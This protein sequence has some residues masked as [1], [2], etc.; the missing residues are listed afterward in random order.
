M[1]AYSALPPSWPYLQH[2]RW[3]QEAQGRPQKGAL[4]GPFHVV[5]HLVT[6]A[7]LLLGWTLALLFLPISTEGRLFVESAQV[8]VTSSWGLGHEA[9][10]E[11]LFKKIR[12]G[13]LLGCALGVVW[14]PI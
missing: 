14:K 9:D 1:S 2:G 10:E 13:H 4:G 5:A 11:A 12:G 7:P 3:K 6:L 8:S